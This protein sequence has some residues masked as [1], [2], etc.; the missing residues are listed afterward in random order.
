MPVVDIPLFLFIIESATLTGDAQL[1]GVKF[2]ISCFPELLLEIAFVLR[3]LIG[4]DGVAGL[5]IC[6]KVVTL[7]SAWVV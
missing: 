7:A 2:L 1:F 4:P 3:Y 6:E 5:A